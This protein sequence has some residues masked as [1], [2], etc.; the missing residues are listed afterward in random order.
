MNIGLKIFL[1]FFAALFFL[2]II[3]M[4]KKKYLELYYSIVWLLTG[5]SFLILAIFDN[6]LVFIS[7][8]IF[9]K[10]PVN[11]LFLIVLFFVIIILLTLTVALSK[12][13]RRIVDLSQEIALIKKKYM[14]EEN[15]DE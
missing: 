9:V 1:I 15:L 2:V 5:M 7:K 10:E 6:I 8:V 12:I 13:T 14:S 11:A 3:R 4:V